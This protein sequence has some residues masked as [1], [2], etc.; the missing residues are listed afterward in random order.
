MFLLF[1]WRRHDFLMRANPFGRSLEGGGPWKRNSK[2]SHQNHSVQVPYKTT[3]TLVIICTRVSASLAYV[4]PTP[5]QRL[6][7]LWLSYQAPCK[8]Q[9]SGFQ[10]TGGPKVT[11]AATWRPPPP[12]PP[13][14][15]QNVCYFIPPYRQTVRKV[16]V[17][18]NLELNSDI[19][20]RYAFG[21]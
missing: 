3:G 16:F 15:V 11:A 19:C 17:Q 12:P 21:T 6:Y 10:R 4:Y 5:N 14:A 1:T 18:D 8:L 9:L 20:I 7:F 2:K 13:Q